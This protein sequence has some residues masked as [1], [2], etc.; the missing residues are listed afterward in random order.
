M[1][2]NDTK[3][4][5]WVE[6]FADGSCLGNP[7]SGGWAFLLRYNGRELQQWGWKADTTN[8]RM[9]ITAV[10]SG[11]Q[12]LQRPCLVAIYTDSQYV[13]RCGERKNSRKANRDLW[14]LVNKE[15]NRHK[16]LMWN[17]VRGHTGVPEN[18]L[19]DR[20]AWEAAKYQREGR[21]RK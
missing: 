12:C 21:Q 4:T 6:L 2:R 20:L 14:E 16:E 15:E 17:W 10:L 5:A 9:E 1:S 18:E 3:R 8:N 7:G 19:V 13:I 11:L